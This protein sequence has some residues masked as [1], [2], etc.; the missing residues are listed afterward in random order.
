MNFRPDFVLIEKLP[1]ASHILTLKMHHFYSSSVLNE[2]EFLI[3]LDKA[4]TIQPG[5]E[6]LLN[7]NYSPWYSIE[8]TTSSGS[9]ELE[10]YQGG[11]GTL[12]LPNGKKGAVMF[13]LIKK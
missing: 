2:S 12:T 5:S 9:Y 10:L 3:L 7:W 1:T 8:F 13:D 6:I 11:L 4:K